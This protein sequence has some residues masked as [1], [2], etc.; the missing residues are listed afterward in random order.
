MRFN[1]QSTVTVLLLTASLLGS[2]LRF[3]VPSYGDQSH[4]T[5]NQPGEIMPDHVADPH[6]HGQLEIPPGQPVPTIQIQLHPD[7]VSGWNLEVQTT[8]FQ[9]APERVNQSNLPFEGHAHLYINGEK[10]GRIYSPWFYIPQLPA[11]ST[12]LTVQ[13]NTND[14]A[15]LTQN[16]EP[17]QATIQVNVP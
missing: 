9:F 7:V 3:P 1:R 16:G 15:V 2:T 6:S 12:E 14:H 17:I 11:G 5:H 4:E 8:N 10:V 13:L